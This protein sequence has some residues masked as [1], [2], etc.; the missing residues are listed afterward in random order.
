MEQGN[1]CHKWVE[2]YINF[3]QKVRKLCKNEAMWWQIHRRS[4]VYRSS[5]K[6]E[7]CTSTIKI[8]FC[9]VHLT[10]M[11]EGLIMYNF[12]LIKIKS[13]TNK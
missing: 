1:I 4:H 11:Q 2:N 7:V 8:K 6:S 13:S 10:G 12:F 9:V 3:I 5:T